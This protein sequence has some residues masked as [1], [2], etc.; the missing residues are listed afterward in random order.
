MSTCSRLMCPIVVTLLVLQCYSWTATLLASDE[1]QPAGKLELTVSTKGRL[2]SPGHLV[3]VVITLKNNSTALI[4]I[5]ES[6]AATD[7]AVSVTLPN[8]KP[9]PPTLYGTQQVDKALIGSMRLLE[10]Q[11][12]ESHE[13][14]IP[15]S[16]LFDMTL[17]G[18]YGIKVA[19]RIT[20]TRNIEAEELHL[21]LSEEV[22]STTQPKA[23][24]R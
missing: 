5:P 23:T 10:L 20:P 7:F 9:A 21:T 6:N 18:R 14:Q 17:P 1:T 4:A 3:K 11:A 24:D 13:V 2:P 12:G 16:R 19:R 15:I 8:G 22:V